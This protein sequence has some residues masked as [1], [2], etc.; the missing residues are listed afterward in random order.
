M[1]RLDTGGERDQCAVGPAER[2]AVGARD[3]IRLTP[4]MVLT[5]GVREWRRVSSAVERYTPSDD[6]L[7]YLDSL[8]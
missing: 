1:R 5:V 8:G 7:A 3:L 4:V 6:V 2:S